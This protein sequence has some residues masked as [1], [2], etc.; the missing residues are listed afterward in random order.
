MS[1]VSLRRHFRNLT[2]L[3]GSFT[4]EAMRLQLRHERVTELAGEGPRWSDINR[5]G[6]LDNQANV[7]TLAR[8]DHDPDFANFV[9]GKNRLLPIP[10]TE[11]DID[12]N[13]SQ[14]PGY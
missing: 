8:A 14:N 3:A 7:N 5:Y 12:R 9:V 4:Q 2:P 6:L 11:I 13:I 10:Q 1:K